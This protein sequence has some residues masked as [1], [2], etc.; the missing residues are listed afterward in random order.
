MSQLTDLY[1]A[2]VQGSLYARWQ[3]LCLEAA[4]RSLD[5]GLLLC[6]V[7]LFLLEVILLAILI[8]HN[9]AR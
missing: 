4:S 8:T 1:S 9:P 7:A 3:L 2:V 6:R 5:C